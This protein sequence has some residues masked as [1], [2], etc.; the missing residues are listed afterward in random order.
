MNRAADG[1]ASSVDAFVG[2]STGRQK[3]EGSLC[4]VGRPT[5]ARGKDKWPLGPIRRAGVARATET[6]GA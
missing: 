3:L 5:K 2:N 6:R 4:P 1:S